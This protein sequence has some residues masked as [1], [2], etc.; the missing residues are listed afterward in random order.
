MKI[1]LINYGGL[2]PKRAYSNDVGADVYSAKDIVLQPNE[3]EKVPLGIGVDI[4]IG[5]AGFVFPRSG[6]SAKGIGCELPPIDPGYTGEIHAIL[7]N[8]SSKPYRVKAG[9][10]IGQLVVT[11]VAIAEFI[12]ED[13]SQRAA[14]GFG[15]TGK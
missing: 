3:T 1:K 9:D 11:P 6:L 13:Q 10:R 12:T 2:A 4:P 15:S 14:A 7:H 8:I 5:Y